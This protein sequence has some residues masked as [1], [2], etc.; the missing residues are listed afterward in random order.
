MRYYLRKIAMRAGDDEQMINY[1]WSYI[2]IKQSSYFCSIIIL[3][4]RVVFTL[5]KELRFRKL[6]SNDFQLSKVVVP[7]HIH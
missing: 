6:S 1:E 4:N 2:I 5:K 3:P 7:Q